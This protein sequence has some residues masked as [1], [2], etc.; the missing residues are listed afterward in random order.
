VPF[1]RWRHCRDWLLQTDLDSGVSD[2]LFE[3][4]WH[5]I[6]TGNE[7][8]CKDP[9]YCYCLVFGVCFPSRHDLQAWMDQKEEYEQW[10][11]QYLH[12]REAGGEVA[13]FAG[14]I[15]GIAAHLRQDLTHALARGENIQDRAAEFPI[16]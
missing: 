10:V 1:E 14:Q 3:Y 7:S 2:R 6:L 15:A 4:S 13:E 5:F 16:I 11:T 12:M 9:H 8:L